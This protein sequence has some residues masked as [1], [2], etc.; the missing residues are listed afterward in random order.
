[1]PNLTV[2]LSPAR[3]HLRSPLLVAVK[4][5]ILTDMQHMIVTHEVAEGCYSILYLVLH[6]DD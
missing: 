6:S 3:S 5:G 4:A 2:K 1:M